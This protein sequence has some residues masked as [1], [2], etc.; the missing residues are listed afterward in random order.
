MIRFSAAPIGRAP[1][2]SRTTTRSSIARGMVPGHDR[3]R[4]LL[5]PV[6]RPGHEH[7]R[8]RAAPVATAPRGGRRLP[9]WHAGG[10]ADCVQPT[11]SDPTVAVPYAAPAGGDP[12]AK[13]AHNLTFSGLTFSYTSWLHPNTSDGFADQQTG[14]Y[15]VGPRSNYPGGGQSPCSSPPG[16]TGS[17]M[18]AAVQVSNAYNI[19]FVGDRFVA[20]GSLGLGIGNDANAHA[21]GR[22]A[23]GEWHQRHR[24]R[25]LADRRR[26]DRDRGI[27]AWAHH[28]CGDKVCTSSD[29]GAKLIN[30]NMTIKDNLVH[31]V[32]IDYRDFA[33]LMFTYTANVVVSHNE[34]YNVPYSGIAA[35]SGGAPTMR[36]ATT[37]TRRAHREP[38]QIPALYVN[39]PP[40]RTTPSAP[41]TSTWVC[42]R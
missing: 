38:L 20:L 24:L 11:G 22:R 23:R 32:G 13:P 19:S 17:Q 42:S 6:V 37:T 26:R 7:G 16:R 29:P 21:D 5:H 4:A 30:Q 2:T 40:P 25:V 14:G 28:P 15:L 10:G 34:V 18:P 35:V 31:D 8:R 9:R 41:T 3:R 1:S 27:Q 12:Y 33:G 39:R 36:A